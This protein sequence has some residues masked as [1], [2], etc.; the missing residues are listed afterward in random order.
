MN[1]QMAMLENICTLDKASVNP[2]LE[3]LQVSKKDDKLI[4]PR[5]SS[6]HKL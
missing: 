4:L 6:Q 1:D 5:T 2:G 3:E